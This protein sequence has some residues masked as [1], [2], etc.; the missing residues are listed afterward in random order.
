MK[1]L[2]SVTSAAR[3]HPSVRAAL[4]TPWGQPGKG[5]SSAAKEAKAALGS[6]LNEGA[7]LPT[8]V[9][10]IYQPRTEAQQR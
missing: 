4:P 9:K 1:A 7:E 6:E 2:T 8:P 5:K 3:A 10:R